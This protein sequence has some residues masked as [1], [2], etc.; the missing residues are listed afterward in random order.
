MHD[1]AMPPADPR[2]EFIAALRELAGYLAE[3]PGLPVPFGLHCVNVFPARSTD[4]DE[5]AWVDQFAALTG[6]GRAEQDRH[7]TAARLFGPIEYAAVAISSA[8]RAAYQAE[9]SYHNCVEPNV[10]S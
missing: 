3:H 6:A 7:Y 9:A 10:R 1:Q 8:R 4:A 2:A 5:R